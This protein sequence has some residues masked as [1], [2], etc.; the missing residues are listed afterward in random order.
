MLRAY[1]AANTNGSALVMRAFIVLLLLHPDQFCDMIQN[2]FE[3]LQ[4]CAFIA[5]CNF[6]KNLAG[7]DRV[8]VPGHVAHLPSCAN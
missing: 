8:G 3:I 5:V 2:G 7:Y 6:V 1:P 4:S